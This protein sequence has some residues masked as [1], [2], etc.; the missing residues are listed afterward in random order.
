LPKPQSHT[1]LAQEISLAFGDLLPN[2]ICH[3]RPDPA[4][5]FMSKWF[6]T[7]VAAS[8]G[9][10]QANA[11]GEPSMDSAPVL[12]YGPLSIASFRRLVMLISMWY[13]PIL[14]IP[15]S[16][17]EFQVGRVRLREHSDPLLGIPRFDDDAIEAGGDRIH[18][19]IQINKTLARPAVHIDTRCR[20]PPVLIE[21]HIIDLALK[22]HLAKLS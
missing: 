7:S 9:E 22:V 1:W 14:S 15:Y 18:A 5:R 16:L 3:H 8:E 21:G 6:S 19:F 13:A 12:S 11:I 20:W 10:G 4:V 2:A 17:P